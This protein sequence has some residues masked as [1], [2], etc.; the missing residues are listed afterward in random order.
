MLF[1]AA[2]NSSNPN[3]QPF[4]NHRGVVVRH[5]FGCE[6][7]GARNRSE[8]SY[9]TTVVSSVA[10]HRIS[11][12]GPYRLKSSRFDRFSFVTHSFFGTG[13]ST[14]ACRTSSRARVG[15]RNVLSRATDSHQA[16]EFI[17]AGSFGN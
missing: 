17:A 3:P 16:S 14:T 10:K 2:G 9:A 8:R 13:V 15:F 6:A 1:F 4:D 7:F 11:C 12:A 5:G